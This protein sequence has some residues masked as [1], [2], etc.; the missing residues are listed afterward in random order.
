MKKSVCDRKKFAYT[1]LSSIPMGSPSFIERI[2][3][4]S[5]RKRSSLMI[6]RSFSMRYTG[7]MLG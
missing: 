4:F 3:S 1:W 5:R 2:F 7:L 6:L